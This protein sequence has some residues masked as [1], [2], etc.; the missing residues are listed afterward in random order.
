VVK[1]V[2][3]AE[4]VLTDC[5]IE[6]PDVV[7]VCF[8]QRGAV[9]EVEALFSTVASFRANELEHRESPDYDGNVVAGVER[10]R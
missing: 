9:A 10:K 2:R 1:V 4:F 8:S 3:G 5:Y 7:E 6:F